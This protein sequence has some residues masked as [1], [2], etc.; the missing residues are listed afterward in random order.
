MM[1]GYDAVMKTL[2]SLRDPDEIS[3][4]TQLSALGS[5]LG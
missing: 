3:R 2:P 5:M 1:R 4:L